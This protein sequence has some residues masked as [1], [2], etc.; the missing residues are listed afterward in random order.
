MKYQ[1][2]NV[3][4]IF[5][6]GNNR[7]RIFYSN[8]NYLYFKEKMI[9]H[10]LPHADILAYCLMP[11]HFH[12]LINVKESGCRPSIIKGIQ[13]RDNSN[14]SFQQQLSHEIAI[15]LRSFTR[16]INKQQERTGSLFRSGTKSKHID[17]IGPCSLQ[18]KVPAGN[19]NYLLDCF[20]YIHQNPVKADMVDS[21]LDWNYS[22]AIE[23][24]N[25]KSECICNRLLAIKYGLVE[26]V[27]G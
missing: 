2:G 1:V 11:N 15:L 12:W 3:Y 19:N 23:Y 10:I 14:N 13:S 20:N 6:Q 9:K 21:M 24:Y 7:E 5:N 18:S 17:L 27:V 22:S 25:Y 16:A 8:R 26:G 4:H